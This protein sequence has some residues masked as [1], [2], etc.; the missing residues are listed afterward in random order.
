MT[1]EILDIREGVVI[2]D[3]IESYQYS[4]KDPDNGAANLNTAGTELI[5]TFENSSVFTYPHG[6][7]LRVEGIL[8][9]AANANWSTA[10]NGSA[11][12]FVNNGIM[13]L[14]RNFKYELGGQTVEYFENAGIATTIHNYLTKSS[15]YQGESWFWVPDKV[16]IDADINN[17]PFK[18]R[19]LVIN[20]EDNAAAWYFS[21][22]IYLS[23][24]SS[25]CHDY[26]KV[27]WGVKH[28]IHLSREVSTRACFRANAQ[29]NASGYYPQLAAVP[30]DVV[31]S[32]NKLRWCV[33]VAKPAAIQETELLSIVG[34]PE[35]FISI[36]FL[37]KRCD[38]YAIAAG[39]TSMSQRLNTTS[40]I[41]RPRYIIIAFQVGLF[42]D[43][44]FN[45]AAF[46]P[47]DEINIIEAYINLNNIRYPTESM[48]TNHETNTYN[49]W[50]TNYEQFY[51]KYNSTSLC[52]PCLGLIDFKKVAPLY[53]FDVSNQPENLKGATVDVMLYLTFGAAIPANTTMYV[54]T[55]FDSLYQISATQI[56][57]VLQIINGSPA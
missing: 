51:R 46:A 25:F 13:R 23:D 5:F 1:S 11:I 34:N 8:K 49:K 2:D 21:A 37:N 36:P 4:E 55:Y 27:L 44:T 43:Q 16:V 17:V 26:R 9:T 10:N 33:P 47:S 38:S 53:V 15:G 57:P 41:E 54:L 28:R 35:S 31:I 24:I 52:D 39:G 12:A 18:I 40:G 48:T 56:R 7:Y 19:N 3:S 6:S 32:F 42:G 30:N 45:S 14:F 20:P 29:I 50:Y 22:N